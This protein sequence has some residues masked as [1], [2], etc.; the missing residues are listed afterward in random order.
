MRNRGMA[1]SS[2]RRA[3]ETARSPPGVRTSGRA[4][5]GAGYDGIQYVHHLAASAGA[6]L[7]RREADVRPTVVNAAL[8]IPAAEAAA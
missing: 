7:R 8:T 5:R 4:L 2:I 6:G 3:R 1:R